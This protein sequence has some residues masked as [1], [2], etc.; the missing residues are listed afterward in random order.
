M[1][2]VFRRGYTPSA[3]RAGSTTRSTPRKPTQSVG[4]RGRRGE[5]RRRK[6]R[7]SRA[8]SARCCWKGT[9]KMKALKARAPLHGSLPGSTSCAEEASEQT[10]PRPQLAWPHSELKQQHSADGR[11]LPRMHRVLRARSPR[12]LWRTPRQREQW[13]H[14]WR[15]T[16]LAGNPTVLSC[17]PQ[18]QENNTMRQRLL[19]AVVS[20]VV[21]P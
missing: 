10:S 2:W 20:P 16:W 17:V 8:C 9:G 4:G 6:L 13:R 15:T 14:L 12:R 7:Y 1:C 11:W 18:T 21:Q 19:Q 5:T 3:V